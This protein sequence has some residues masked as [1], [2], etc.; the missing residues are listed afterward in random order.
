[1]R[2]CYR[3]AYGLRGVIEALSHYEGFR[4]IAFQVRRNRACGMADADQLVYLKELLQDIRD[5]HEEED[6][7]ESDL[8]VSVSSH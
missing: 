2:T 3:R 7:P 4:F 8:I 1:M 5:R 6:L